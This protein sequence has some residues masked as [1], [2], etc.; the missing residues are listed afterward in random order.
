MQ[1]SGVALV[2][3]PQRDCR[4]DNAACGPRKKVMV[5][6]IDQRNANHRSQNQE[7][8]PQAYNR[9]ENVFHSATSHTT[10]GYP[11]HAWQRFRPH[12]MLDSCACSKSLTLSL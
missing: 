6:A 9:Y 4:V 10:C 7:Q 12:R 5:V 2:A 11:N 1:I 3:Q 8:K